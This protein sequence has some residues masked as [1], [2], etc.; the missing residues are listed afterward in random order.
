MMET[1]VILKIGFLAILYIPAADCTI[2]LKFCMGKQNSIVM[3]I[4]SHKLQI[5]KIQNGGRPPFKKSLKHHAFA[6]NHPILMK[7]SVY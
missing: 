6:K 1:A 4:T 5:L 3:V 7:F 2:S